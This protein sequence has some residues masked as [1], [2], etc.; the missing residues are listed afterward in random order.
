M[1]RL[2]TENILNT[3]PLAAGRKLK[4][5]ILFTLNLGSVSVILQQC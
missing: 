5:H 4:V 2:K 1:R 3:S